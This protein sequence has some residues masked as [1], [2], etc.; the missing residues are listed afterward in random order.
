VHKQREGLTAHCLPTI[1]SAS[2]FGTNFIDDLHQPA[3]CLAPASTGLVAMWAPWKTGIKEYR[4][5]SH[6]HVILTA[7]PM[8]QHRLNSLIVGWAAEAN[9]HHSKD[10]EQPTTAEKITATKQPTNFTWRMAPE[11][12]E[13]GAG[14]AAGAAAGAGAVSFDP[15]QA[16]PWDFTNQFVPGKSPT[17]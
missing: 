2:I 10:A 7:P 17:L 13:P 5:V 14:A 15:V 4:N 3:C 1:S 9:H 11:A 6:L 16:H 12:S 8:S